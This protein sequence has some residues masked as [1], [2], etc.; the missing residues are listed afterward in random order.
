MFS[1]CIAV[2]SCWLC[3]A[4]ACSVAN[5]NGWGLVGASFAFSLAVTTGACWVAYCAGRSMGRL[6]LRSHRW[7]MLTL[8]CQL[9]VGP[10]AVPTW[11][12]EQCDVRGY[13][14]TN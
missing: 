3:R 12:E 7:T 8:A 5:C 10:E 6:L 13:K 1:C 4:P 9:I 11:L 2:V 14:M